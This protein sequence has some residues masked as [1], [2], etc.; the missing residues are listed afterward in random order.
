MKNQPVALPF[1]SMLFQVLKSVDGRTKV[2]GVVRA[3]KQSIAISFDG[4]GDC[5]SMEGYGEPVFIELREDG[6]HLVVWADINQEDPTHDI[7]LSGAR[8]DRRKPE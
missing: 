1:E 6:L 8:E 3:T 4:Y 5:V 7:N 2:R